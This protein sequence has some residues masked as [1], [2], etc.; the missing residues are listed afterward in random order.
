MNAPATEAVALRRQLDRYR[1]EIDETL[2]RIRSEIRDQNPVAAAM[3]YALES[4]GKRLRPILCLATI[5]AIRGAHEAEHARAAAA[6]ELIHTYSLVHDDLPCMDD[7][8]LRRGRPTAHRVFGSPAAAAAGFALIPFALRVLAE[9]VLRLGLPPRERVAAVHEVCA[10]AGPAG[11]VGGQILDLEAEGGSLDE[12]ALRQVH[13]MKTGALFSAAVRLGATLAG[14][15]GTQRDALG[16]YGLRLGLAFQIR[17][18][19]LDVTTDAEAL[20]KTPG[21]DAAADKA[22]FSA[23]LG[24][25]AADAAARMEADA[26]VAALA[27]AGVHAPTLV[28]LARFA[29]VRER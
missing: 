11:M 20:G 13:A 1:S 10:G 25:E 3:S 28:S 27:T 2:S 4:G 12:R 8:A 26:A 16:V 7:D 24:T 5:D 15:H 19:V 17:D 21:K 18:D 14:A 6:L 23:L 29:A 22:T 9:A